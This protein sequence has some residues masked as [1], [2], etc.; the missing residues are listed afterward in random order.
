M[1][2]STKPVA[3][4]G[5]LDN[6]F[7]EIFPLGA[8]QWT[9]QQTHVTNRLCFM[10][11][12]TTLFW[13]SRLCLVVVLRLRILFQ[14]ERELNSTFLFVS[15]VRRFVFCDRCCPNDCCAR[16]YVNKKRG[17]RDAR[18][19]RGRRQLVRRPAG[20]PLWQQPAIMTDR[21]EAGGIM[22]ASI[23]ATS[24]RFAFCFCAKQQFVPSFA[25]EVNS[26][27]WLQDEEFGFW[28]FGEIANQFRIRILIGQPSLRVMC[29]ALKYW[30]IQVSAH[31]NKS[32]LKRETTQNGSKGR[33]IG[34]DQTLFV[35][36]TVHHYKA[37]GPVALIVIGHLIR[38]PSLALT[39][40]PN[41][42][43]EGG[44]K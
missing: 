23:T 35:T 29:F 21:H 22:I 30:I 38:A 13:Y 14:E 20:A 3:H 44:G 43:N 31:Q 24:N 17:S 4:V 28:V 39:F 26:N 2:I 6:I 10:S 41:H 40:A 33:R 42:N 12:F 15:L 25:T 34:I 18:G 9:D 16:N 37:L 19:K 8:K 11:I 7:V 1:L 36:F 5:T 27:D 32:A